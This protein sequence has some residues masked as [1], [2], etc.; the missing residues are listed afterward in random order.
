MQEQLLSQIAKLEYDNITEVNLK[1]GTYH[2]FSRQDAEG[3]Q[4]PASGEFWEEVRALAERM[5]EEPSRKEYLE[6]LDYRYMQE[7]LDRQNAYTFIVEMKD[8]KNEL[9]VKRFH[10]FSISRELDRVCVARTD[11][12]DVVRQEQRQK[13]CIRDRPA[14]SHGCYVQFKISLVEMPDTGDITGILTVTDRCV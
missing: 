6:K 7:Q 3:N 8:D 13:M 10:V 11:V 14:K 4:L 1:K 12:T 5:M 9:R 2:I